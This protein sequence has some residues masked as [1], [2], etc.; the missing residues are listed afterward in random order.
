LYKNRKFILDENNLR[1]Q[2]KNNNIRYKI[3]KYEFWR[4]NE[5]QYQK[6]KK[7]YNKNKNLKS[8]DLINGFCR[9]EIKYYMDSNNYILINM[10]SLNVINLIKKIMK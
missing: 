6:I 7:I 10:H 2:Q 8:N 3:Y 1:Y 4:K 9:G 5:A